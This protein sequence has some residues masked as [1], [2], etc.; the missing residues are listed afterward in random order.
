MRTILKIGAI[1]LV[2]FLFAGCTP[3]LQTGSTLLGVYD[4]DIVL[5]I[6]TNPPRAKLFEL[7]TSHMHRST[8]YTLQIAAKECLKN[9]K[10]YFYI[11]KPEMLNP[12]NGSTINSLEEFRKKCTVSGFA[13]V[14]SLKS[15]NICK[16]LTMAYSV[17]VPTKGEMTIVAIDNKPL[18]FFVFD[19][20]EVI[21]ELKK[22]EMYIEN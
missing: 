18:D 15:S 2:A 7:S 5:K 9:G 19:A 16:I 17:K 10:N 3:K 6:T 13:D 8:I 1:V 12:K 11:K 22:S 21:D 14:I 20:K 4:S